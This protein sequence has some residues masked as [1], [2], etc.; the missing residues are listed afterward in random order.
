[1][2]L[3]QFDIVFRGVR[4][5]FDA[6]VVKA[7]FASL[8]RLDDAKVDRIFKSH[9]LVLK[10]KL[11][12]RLANHYARRLTLMGVRIEKRS[13]ISSDDKTGQSS[14]RSVPNTS[15]TISV[16]PSKAIYSRDLGEASSE[17][18]SMHQPVA[19]VYGEQVRRIPFVFT[20]DGFDFFKIWIVNCLVILLSAGM[21]YPWVQVRNLRYFYQHTRLD[22]AEFNY[23]S[24][25]Q[26]I[27]LL[28]FAIILYL[29]TLGIVFCYS[30]LLFVIGLMVLIGLF[31]AYW[32]QQRVFNARYSR[33]RSVGLQHSATLLQTY[34]VCL[35]WPAAVLC[36]LGVMA[37]LAI[38]YIQRDSIETKSFGDYPFRMNAHSQSYWQLLPPLL[39]AEAMTCAI[40]YYHQKILLWIAVLLIAIVWLVL[41]LRWRVLLVNLQWGAT[42]CKLGS[43]VATWDFSS[44]VKLV[45]RNLCLCVISAGFYWPWAKV[46]MAQYKAQHLAVFVNPRFNKWVKSLKP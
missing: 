15:S 44:Y 2:S 26:K 32:F 18:W 40:V 42:T 24:Q 31:P 28:Q 11:D 36:S 41:F 21:L 30:S 17:S 29:L 34:K 27:F 1:M 45:L 23:T 13:L 39:M 12:E 3:P 35:L 6:A 20:G 38:F 14:L 33:Y 10:H 46:R 4:K 16:A 5:G 25:P 9:Q 19:M 37:P 22:N 7:E 43:F 8:F